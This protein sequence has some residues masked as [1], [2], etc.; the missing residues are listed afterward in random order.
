[1][2]KRIDHVALA[3]KDHNAA[4]EFFTKLFGAIPGP[5]AE[6]SSMKYIWRNYILGDLSRLEILSP[7]GEGSFLDGFLQNKKGGI[8]H[9]TMQCD[10]IYE[11]KKFLEDSGIP[12]FDFNDYDNW[13]ELFIHPRDAF[14]LLIQIAQ[15]EAEHWIS[16]KAVQKEK[17]LVRKKDSKTT[18]SVNHPGG[19]IIEINLTNEERLKLIEKLKR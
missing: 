18:I 7:T 3:V 10:D 5:G 12:Y 1:M 16:E 19:G 6:D 2:I 8:H 17:F 14:G 13:K 9:V 15:F 4:E 11:T